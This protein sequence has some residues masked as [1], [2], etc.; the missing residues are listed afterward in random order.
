MADGEALLRA[1]LGKAENCVRNSVQ[2]PL[3]DNQFAAIVSF[4]FNRTPLLRLLSLS[5]S[6]S[7]SC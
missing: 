7:L 6:L 5:L 2:V 3:N 1:D 4:T